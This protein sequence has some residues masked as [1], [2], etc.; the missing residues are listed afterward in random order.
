MDIAIL[1]VG[2]TAQGLRQIILWF[3]KRSICQ[4]GSPLTHI[5]ERK[6]LGVLR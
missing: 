3:L 4:L 5:C 1:I 2:E 6:S